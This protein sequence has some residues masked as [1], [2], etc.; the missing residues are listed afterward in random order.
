MKKNRIIRWL[1]VF[2][3]IGLAFFI[4]SQFLHF[5]GWAPR[6][7]A[8]WQ[9][10][11]SHMQ[12]FH[13]G[14]FHQG[15]FGGPGGMGHFGRGHGI[16]G[17]GSIIAGFILAALGWILRKNAGES[18]WKKWGGWLLIGMGTLMVITRILPLVIFI[19]IGL[20]IW[21][22]VRKGKTEHKTGSIAEDYSL[23]SIPTATTQTGSMLDEWERKITKEDNK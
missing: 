9:N 18:L 17:F 23:D 10:G 4:G 19:V 8:A 22:V 2:A 1:F 3:A 16:F 6:N 20:V 5:G 12:A 14:G 15:Q 13:H 11:G 7:I 21:K